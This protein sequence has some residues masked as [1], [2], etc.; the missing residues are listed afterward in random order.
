MD[1]TG[2][3]SGAQTTLQALGRQGQNQTQIITT[4][5]TTANILNESN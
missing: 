5:C 3:G 4:N 1:S 2:P